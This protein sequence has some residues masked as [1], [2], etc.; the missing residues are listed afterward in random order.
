MPVVFFMKLF[1]LPL[2]SHKNKQNKKSEACCYK[3]SNVVAYYWKGDWWSH[4]A[5]SRMFWTIFIYRWRGKIPVLYLKLHIKNVSLKYYPG[6][7]AGSSF[8]QASSYPEG[9]SLG[10]VRF[11]DIA[12]LTCLTLHFT[13]LMMLSTHDR[14]FT[15]VSFVCFRFIYFFL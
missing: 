11:D 13:L 5:R 10:F 1:T 8:V 9:K 7:L 2:F 4:K 14:S 3:V 6:G 15:M 12:F